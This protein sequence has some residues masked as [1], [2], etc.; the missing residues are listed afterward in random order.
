[1]SVKYRLLYEYSGSKGQT[2]WSVQRKRRFLFWTFWT[3]TAFAL[4]FSQADKL[5][6]LLETHQ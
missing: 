4:P 3:T 6:T 1:M 2:Y 5:A